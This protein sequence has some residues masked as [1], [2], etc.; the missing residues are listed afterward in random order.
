LRINVYLLIKKNTKSV[1]AVA[2]KRRHAGQ[3]ISFMTSQPITGLATI[4]SAQS[5][6]GIVLYV[7]EVDGSSKKIMNLVD[8][9]LL[10][11]EKTC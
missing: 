9:N 4:L 8:G 1:S 11:M 7:D 3:Y 2:V 10:K 6:F 5:K